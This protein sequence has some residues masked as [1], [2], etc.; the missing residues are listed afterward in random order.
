MTGALPVTDADFPGLAEAVAQE[1]LVRGA[2]CLGIN[3]LIGGCEVRPL[4]AYH[5]RRL[6]FAG[7]PFLAKV[8]TEQLCADPANDQWL[9]HHLMLFLWIVSPFYEDSGKTSEPPPRKRFESK[10]KYA[11]RCAAL[12]TN[13]DRFNLA[14]AT[15]LKL[16]LDQLTREILEYVEESYLDAEDGSPS[17]D[18]AQ[19]CAFEIQIAQELHSN[20]SR[21]YRVDFWNPE[22]QP[23]KNPLLVP[24]KIIFQLRKAR[25]KAAGENVTNRSQ[26][27]ISEGLAKLGD[28]HRRLEEYIRDLHTQPPPAVPEE[29]DRVKLFDYSEN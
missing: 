4:T 14:F 16:P 5:I 19:Y 7:S 12:Q 2:A 3:E 26:Q 21:S 18:P 11:A 15:I 29:T 24:L 28:L 8:T 23:S 25:L 10:K 20:Y 13:R 27:K 17:A 6:T 1:N 9:L 22:I